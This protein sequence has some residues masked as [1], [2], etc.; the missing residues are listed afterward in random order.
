MTIAPEPL[1]LVADGYGRA[2]DRV[3][4]ALREMI[5]NGRLSPGEH[6]RQDELAGRL[7]STRVPVREAFKTLVAEGVLVHRPNHGHYVSKLTSGELAEI[8]WLRDACENRL[9]LTAR[10]PDEAELDELDTRN[11]AMKR[12]IGGTPYQI[13]AADR[14]FHEGFWTLSPMRIVAHEA[15][16]MWGLIQPYRSFMDY[17]TAVV[18]RMHAEHGAIVAALR[19]RDREAYTSAVE[20]H[21][22]HIYGV[23][24]A[25]AERERAETA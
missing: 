9:A 11:D 15:A 2:G 25:L 18:T 23:I 1:P 24:E 16:R 7:G 12:L 6:L 20:S 19:A 17:G 21:Q 13:V 8:C 3:T 4:A 5:A 14:R 22:R 10:W